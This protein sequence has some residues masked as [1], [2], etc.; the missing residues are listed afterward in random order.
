MFSFSQIVQRALRNVSNGRSISKC[1]LDNIHI[2]LQS[3]YNNIRSSKRTAIISLGVS[4]RC[5]GQRQRVINCNNIVIFFDCNLLSRICGINSQICIQ[6]LRSFNYSNFCTIIHR[7]TLI[8]LYLLF[9]APQIVMDR[10]AVLI[11]SAAELSCE[12]H[13]AL[14]CRQCIIQPVY[15]FSALPAAECIRVL[16]ICCLSRN[17]TVITR[18]CAVRYVCICF[19]SRFAVLP[20][21]S[22]IGYSCGCRCRCGCRCGSRCIG[23]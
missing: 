21:Y 4:A 9:S 15:S 19:N 8:S 23:H 22:V 17:R 10:I 2:V 16:R 6:I 11:N 20:G 14:H 12:D 3:T 18:L 13:V 5:N 1:S 7:S